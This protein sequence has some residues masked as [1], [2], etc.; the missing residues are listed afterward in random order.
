MTF[1]DPQTPTHNL[2]TRAKN[3]A[4]KLRTF[5]TTL[6]SSLKGKSTAIALSLVEAVSIDCFKPGVIL[7]LEKTNA[8]VPQDYLKTG[9]ETI[10][11]SC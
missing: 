7:N 4:E 8:T 1:S 3:E 5:C 11:V 6:K 10:E 9:S 2:L